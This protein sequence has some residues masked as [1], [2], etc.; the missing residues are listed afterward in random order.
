MPLSRATQGISVAV[1]ALRVPEAGMM[2]PEALTSSL[3]P[4]RNGEVTGAPAVYPWQRWDKVEF[5]SYLK[6]SYSA[7][8][9]IFEEMRSP[10]IRPPAD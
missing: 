7:L 5:R 2:G 8:Q 6:K 10:P 9:S 3:P 1:F 4:V